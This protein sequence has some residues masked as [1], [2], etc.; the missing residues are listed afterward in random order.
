MKYN[1]CCIIK[2]NQI[3]VIEEFSRI[4]I[5]CG[6]YTYDFSGRVYGIQMTFNQSLM[7]IKWHSQLDKNYKNVLLYLMKNRKKRRFYV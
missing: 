3:P 2:K 1:K 6:R 7:T 4:C 5:V